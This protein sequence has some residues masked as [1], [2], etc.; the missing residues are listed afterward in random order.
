MRE[1]LEDSCFCPICG[2]R[3]G[4]KR[5]GIC[6]SCNYIILEDSF[7]RTQKMSKNEKAQYISYILNI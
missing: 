2:N 4:D 6:D 5:F 7:L 3:I 1:F